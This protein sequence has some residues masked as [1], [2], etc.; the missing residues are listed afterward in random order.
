MRGVR[1]G[2]VPVAVAIA[3]VLWPPIF[4]VLSQ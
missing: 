2:I 1:H 4:V 3:I